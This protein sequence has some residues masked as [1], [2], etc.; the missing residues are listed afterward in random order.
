VLALWQDANNE[1][2][3]MMFNYVN[4]SEMLQKLG[5]EQIMMASKDEAK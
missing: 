3:R 2:P 4:A 5:M 1:P